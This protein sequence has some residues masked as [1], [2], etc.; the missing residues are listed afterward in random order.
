M[1]SP[2]DHAELVPEGPAA[3]ARWP[4][5]APVVLGGVVL[6]G[7]AAVAVSD[8]VAELVPACPF[9]AL[10][11]LDCP[12]CGG[13]RAVRALGGGQ[14]GTAAGSNVLVVLAIPLVLLGW[15]RWL[16]RELRP[17]A[18]RRA[19]P[20]WLAPTL[21]TL[22]LAFAVARNLDVAGLSWMASAG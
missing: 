6:A 16:R 12:L 21:T 19:A 11:G 8:G 4:W 20:R 3:L 13:T 15:A 7:C 10:T 5:L 9:R 2:V 18:G 1:S 14:L 17:G 22:A